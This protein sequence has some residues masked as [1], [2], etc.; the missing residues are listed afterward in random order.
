[1]TTCTHTETCE[2]CFEA[3]R[4]LKAEA[5]VKNEL[6]SEIAKKLDVHGFKGEQQ[7]RLALKR[8]DMLLS[9][10]KTL[11]ATAEKLVEVMDDR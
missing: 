6:R 1:M 2:S 8:I 9:A 5:A 7:L 3:N 10:E 4:K 11:L